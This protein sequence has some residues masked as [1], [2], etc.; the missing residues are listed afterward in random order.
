MWSRTSVI[1]YI[2]RAV[3]RV[4]IVTFRTKYHKRHANFKNLAISMR[5]NEMV[6]E[7]FKHC[8]AFV[9]L[10]LKG[11]AV[12]FFFFDKSR[13]PRDAQVTYSLRVSQI[14][15]VKRLTRTILQ[16]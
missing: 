3:L 10:W 4:H 8:M 6:A 11:D 16:C 15:W 1:D 7:V 5:K 13:T 9:I 2:S 14:R 12:H